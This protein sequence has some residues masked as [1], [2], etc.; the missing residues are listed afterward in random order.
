MI[1]G[2]WPG[3]AVIANNRISLAAPHYGFAYGSDRSQAELQSD[4]GA[5]TPDCQAGAMGTR[6]SATLTVSMRVTATATATG[7]ARYMSTPS[8]CAVVAQKQEYEPWPNGYDV[9]R[10]AGSVR[11]RLT[12]A[13]RWVVTPKEAGDHRLPGKGSKERSHHNP[14]GSAQ[15]VKGERYT[16]QTPVM[17]S[18][19]ETAA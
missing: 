14:R 13:Q 16:A 11:A 1:P 3:G 10:D 2:H 9:H 6:R 5:A 8:K 7:S 12:S 15:D 17:D 19:V 18:D 4:T